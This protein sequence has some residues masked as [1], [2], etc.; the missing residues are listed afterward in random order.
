M[1]STLTESLSLIPL[2]S[3][4]RS[5]SQCLLYNIRKTSAETFLS[6]R[7]RALDILQLD[8]MKKISN[9]STQII[10]SST[11]PLV[12]LL[13]LLRPVNRSMC[14]KQHSKLDILISCWFLNAVVLNNRSSNFKNNLILNNRLKKL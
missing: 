5:P 12:F 6:N 1:S 7:K 2:A 9:H 8:T 11:F 4:G 13:V 3:T 10:T 14:R